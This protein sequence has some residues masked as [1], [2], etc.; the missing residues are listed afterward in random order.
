MNA[1][2]VVI[3]GGSGLLGSLLARRFH[4]GGAEVV[5]LSRHP[6]LAPWRV[7][8]WDGHSLGA[9]AGEIN[10]T[11]AVINLAGRSVNC[12]YNDSNH[13]E[14]LRSRIDST[15]AIRKAIA[16]ATNPPR[17]W[18]QMSTATIYAHRTDAANDEFTG[19]IGG[20]EPDAPDSWRF[21]IDVAKQWEA[22]VNSAALP[23]T[24]RVILRTA[25]VMSPQRHGTFATLRRLVRL[26]LGGRAASGRQYMSWIHHLDF[27]R[28]V[29]F[30]IGRDDLP[31][32]VNLAAPEPLPNA[33]FMRAL[34]E[35]CGV[36]VGLPATRWMLALGAWALRSETELIL[37]SRRVVPARLL[38]RGFEFAYPSWPE[39][40]RDLCDEPAV[41]RVAIAAP[42]RTAGG[43]TW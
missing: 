37:K 22:E 33:D 3:A 25:M 7:A 18:L 21:S 17:V 30:L 38:Q 36:R 35:A 31:G 34:R 14:I 40:A 32:V 27:V 24:R 6:A 29:D 1:S 42:P 26:G 23:R 19:L 11:D 4:D 13:D 39:A 10:G 8:E 2:R 20:I 15:R 16:I 28:A 9:W 12:R 5:V 43:G 41:T